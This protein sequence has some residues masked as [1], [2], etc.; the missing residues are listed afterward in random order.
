MLKH[1]SEDKLKQFH[2]LS[3]IVRCIISVSQFL[4]ENDSFVKLRLCK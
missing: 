1:S 4:K 2:F 3:L